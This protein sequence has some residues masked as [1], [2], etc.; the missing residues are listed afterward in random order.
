MALGRQ[1]H[2]LS[3]DE[4]RKANINPKQFRAD[5]AVMVIVIMNYGGFVDETTLRAWGI[6]PDSPKILWVPEQGAPIFQFDNRQLRDIVGEINELLDAQGDPS[7][8]CDFWFMANYLASNQLPVELLLH[9]Q[10]ALL[11]DLA[12][13]DLP[14]DD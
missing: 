14:L 3:D 11:I 8:V 6:D 4:L 5:R 12:K 9:G 1:M 7:G 13:A 2:P 10:H